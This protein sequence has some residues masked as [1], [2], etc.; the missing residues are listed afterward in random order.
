MWCCTCRW[1]LWCR[2]SR[3]CCSTAISGAN[4]FTASF[5]TRRSSPPGSRRR[6]CG[7]G[8]STASTARSTNCWGLL[9]STGRAG[10]TTGTGPCRASSSP[11]CGRIAGTSPSFC[12]R[13]S[14]P[15][16]RPTTRRRISTARDSG[17]SCSPS[18]CR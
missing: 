13:R 12:W 18:R 7:N 5:S 10:S 11:R 8:C 16:T 3:R 4:P 17:A 2:C 9:A 14:R 1:Y 15:S 6:P